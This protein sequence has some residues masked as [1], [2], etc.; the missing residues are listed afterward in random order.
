MPLPQLLLQVAVRGALILLATSLAALLFRRSSAATRHLIWSGGLTASLVVA[1]LPTLG[2][3]LAVLPALPAPTAAIRIDSPAEASPE[4]PAAPSRSVQS[5][6]G[7]G[8]QWSGFLS[9]SPSETPQGGTNPTT[10]AT[11][12][13]NAPVHWTRL[14]VLAWLGGIGVLLLRLL[15]GQVGIARLARTAVPV[16]SPEWNVTLRE[17]G[18]LSGLRPVRFLESAEG[19]VNASIKALRLSRSHSNPAVKRVRPG[20][21]IM[22][23]RTTVRPTPTYM[24]HRQ[25]PIIHRRRRHPSLPAIGGALEMHPPSTVALDAGR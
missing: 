22:V 3:S 15:A 9:S 6:S 24:L 23:M 21:R 2:S 17:P 14:L 16:S 25:F 20:H 8:D 12:P 4:S 13:R 5:A 1:L 7:P 10:V 19:Q 18:I 11:E